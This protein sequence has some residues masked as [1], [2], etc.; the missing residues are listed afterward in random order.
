VPTH[1]N[2]FDGCVMHGT[3]LLFWAS[4]LV[5]SFSKHDVSETGSVCVISFLL[6][7]VTKRSFESLDWTISGPVVQS[8]PVQSIDWDNF[9]L[10]GRSWSLMTGTSRFKG[11]VVGEAQKRWTVA[12][13]ALCAPEGQQVTRSVT[14]LNTAD[15]AARSSDK[16]F[17]SMNSICNL[18]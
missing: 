1:R 17:F 12:M 4:S 2:V 14:L 15:C 10:R 5:L 7:P 18:R 8:S 13:W 11:C 6:R 9:C 3:S 16:S